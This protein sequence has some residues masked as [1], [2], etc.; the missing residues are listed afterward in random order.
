MIPRRAHHVSFAVDDLERSKRFYEQVLELEPLPRPEFG[1]RGAWY[2]AGNVQLHLIARPPGASGAGAD[3]GFSPIAN[4][5]AFGID[6]Y[7]KTLSLLRERG[8]EVLET[9]PGVG[10]Q[11][12]FRDPDGNVIELTALR[13]R[14]RRQARRRRFSRSLP[15]DAGRGRGERRHRPAMNALRR[16]GAWSPA[17]V[18]EASRARRAA[19]GSGHAVP[20]DV[21][22][23]SV[24]ARGRGLR[25]LARPHPSNNAGSRSPLLVEPIRATGEDD[26]DQLQRRTDRRLPR[27]IAAAGRHEH[28]VDGRPSAWTA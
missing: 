12:F 28:V 13:T 6:D 21:T 16:A 11:M 9:H 27:M 22:R 23:A 8:V 14:R 10:P 18:D 4:H 26:G 2:R 15:A 7:P 20:A 17:D 25:A 3:A 19:R 1:I 5:T 24:A